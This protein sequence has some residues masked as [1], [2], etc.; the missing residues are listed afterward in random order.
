MESMM[1]WAWIRRGVLMGNG[2]T[3]SR[4]FSLR[5]AALVRLYSTV[6]ESPMSGSTSK[7]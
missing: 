5:S 1:D 3:A 7:A 2:R 6:G 4:R